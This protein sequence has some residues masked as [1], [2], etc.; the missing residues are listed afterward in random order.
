MYILQKLLKRVHLKHETIH[1][2]RQETP[3]FISPYLWSPNTPDRK[4]AD[5][6]ILELMQDRRQCW[7]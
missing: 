4:S 6:Q 3:K 7:N 5:C 1:L 2:R